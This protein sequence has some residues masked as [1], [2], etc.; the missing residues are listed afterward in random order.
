L[1][2]FVLQ[3]ALVGFALNPYKLFEGCGMTDDLVPTGNIQ[4]VPTVFSLG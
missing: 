3:G 4:A 2:K 1:N